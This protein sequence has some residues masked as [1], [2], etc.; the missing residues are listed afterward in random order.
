MSCISH[1]SLDITAIW[2]ALFQRSSQ[3]ALERVME[4]VVKSI[5]KFSSNKVILPIQDPPPYIN[6]NI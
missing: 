1:T 5:P 4:K 3:T 6:T 2:L